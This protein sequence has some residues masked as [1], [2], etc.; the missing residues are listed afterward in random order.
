MKIKSYTAAI[1]LVYVCL[2]SLIGLPTRALA[3]SAENCAASSP[4]ILSFPTWYKYLKPAYVDPDG[5]GPRPAECKLS[6]PLNRDNKPDI[7]LAIGPVLLAVFEII[8]RIGSMVA[9]GFVIFGGFQYILSQGE[10]ERTKGA[11]S[12]IINALIGLVITVF[13]TAIVNVIARNIA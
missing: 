10:P 5:S 3:A 8:L 7:S 1:L 4:G 9:I 13:A 11:R 2:F 6:L 12:T